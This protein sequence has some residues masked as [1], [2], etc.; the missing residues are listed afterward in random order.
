MGQLDMNL[1]ARQ[2]SQ[3]GRDLEAEI[4][5]L[6]Q[7]EDAAVTAEGTFRHYK[8]LHE[9]ALASALLQSKQS[10]AE[11]RKAEARLA[12]RE[13]RQ[14]MNCI[15]RLNWGLTPSRQQKVTK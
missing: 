8:E 7:M 1:L 5:I 6:G 9:D 15:P 2:L 14:L 13:E 12:C 4:A 10:S 11:S 3:L